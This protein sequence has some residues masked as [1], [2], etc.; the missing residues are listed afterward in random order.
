MSPQKWT[1]SS[2]FYNKY[3]RYLQKEDCCN[4]LGRHMHFTSRL[5]FVPFIGDEVRSPNADTL[6]AI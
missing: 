4:D 6:V 5:N 1:I 2:F 3:I